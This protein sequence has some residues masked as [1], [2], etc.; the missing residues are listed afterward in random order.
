MFAINVEE[1]FQITSRN[2]I[3]LLGRTTGVI[4]IGDYLVDQQ[5]N[6]KQFKVIGL[7]MLRYINKDKNF[8]HNPA[9]MIEL[10]DLEPSFLNGRTLQ[11][12]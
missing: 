1:V 11:K 3:I 2:G 8:T 5:D 10:V 6:S 4:H 9:V 7:E 12:L